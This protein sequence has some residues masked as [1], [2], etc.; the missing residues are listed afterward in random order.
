[1]PNLRWKAFL[2]VTWPVRFRK[3]LVYFSDYCLFTSHDSP[4]V[5]QSILQYYSFMFSLSVSL[6]L[7][8]TDRKCKDCCTLKINNSC[9]LDMTS[10]DW[11]FSSVLW[12]LI[13]KQLEIN[14]IFLWFL[15]KI[16]LLMSPG[17]EKQIGKA[18]SSNVPWE[19][20]RIRSVQ[21]I[22]EQD[23]VSF[24]GILPMSETWKYGRILVPG[25]GV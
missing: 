9:S 20:F 11:Y 7:C 15:G 16:K 5:T 12:G 14:L 4:Q 21:E 18:K 22:H 1:M 19:S 17:W 8:K 23:F 24:D 2:K 25:L 6:D 3:V 10:Q 13:L